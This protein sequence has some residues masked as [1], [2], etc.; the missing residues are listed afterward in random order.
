MTSSTTDRL[1]AAQLSK[2]IWINI[3]GAKNPE[4]EDGKFR[5]RKWSF[6]QQKRFGPALLSLIQ[7]FF[8]RVDKLDTTKITEQ[9]QRI[10]SF[11]DLEALKI[12]WGE[13]FRK[14]T[15]FIGE[16][17]VAALQPNFNNDFEK[18][19]QWVDDNIDFFEAKNAWS[20]LR[21]I[22]M[23]QFGHK[24]KNAEGPLIDK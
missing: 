24:P 6:R 14:H 2:W 22:I 3:E 16:I 11:K 5:I 13:L 23:L 17:I 10:T 12:D 4:R 1:E 21:D 9:L 20:L 7:D 19:Y 18:T 8:V 15:D